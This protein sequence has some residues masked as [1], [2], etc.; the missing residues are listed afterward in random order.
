MRPIFEAQI[1]GY[2]AVRVEADSEE[3]AKAKA[4]EAA[5]NAAIDVEQGWDGHEVAGVLAVTVGLE[6]DIDIEEG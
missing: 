4:R 6:E 3:E 2:V 1:S 5:D